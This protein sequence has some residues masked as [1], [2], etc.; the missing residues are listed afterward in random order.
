MP[1]SPL[2]A[3]RQASRVSTPMIIEFSVKFNPS[4]EQ[5]QIV[6]DFK[7]LCSNFSIMSTSRDSQNVF[8]GSL[9]A[10]PFGWYL[11]EKSIGYDGCWVDM[12][13]TMTKRGSASPSAI[14]R[15]EASGKKI[16]NQIAIGT[17]RRTGLRAA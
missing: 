6:R 15:R 2:K 10:T 9:E 13:A 12:G 5:L 4:A 11:C 14:L 16:K 7:G 3:T 17:V 1:A 8:S